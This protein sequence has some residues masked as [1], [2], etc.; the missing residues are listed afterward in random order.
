MSWS[1]PVHSGSEGHVFQMRELRLED[2]DR[3]SLLKVL[4]LTR[5]MVGAHSAFPKPNPS[6]FHSSIMK[7]NSPP[8]SC[9][10]CVRPPTFFSEIGSNLGWLRACSPPASAF[11]MLGAKVCTTRPGKGHHFPRQGPV[12]LVCSH[13]STVLTQSNFRTPHHSTMKLCTH[14]SYACL[15]ATSS[16]PRNH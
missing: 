5:D 16:A 8:Y 2:I 13:N 11:S 4:G 10:S 6:L 1:C 15:P 14:R 3:N 9:P 7:G 12:N